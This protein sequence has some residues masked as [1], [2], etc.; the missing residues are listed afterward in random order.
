[1]SGRN[2]RS[3]E[4]EEEE[5]KTS[6]QFK[7]LLKQ[8]RLTRTFQN[9]E[10][11]AD[12]LSIIG[13]MRQISAVALNGCNTFQSDYKRRA[14]NY[15]HTVTIHTHSDLIHCGG[16]GGSHH[17]HSIG[18]QQLLW[19][20]GRDV[21]HVGKHVNKGDHRDGDEDGAWQVP[22]RIKDKVVD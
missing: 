10:Q 15:T 1:M 12:R 4:T 22:G 21:G 11:K 13:C 6:T 2:I 7:R 16:G 5:E 20:H 14:S 9:G 3:R 8:Q 18:G 17:C 19:A